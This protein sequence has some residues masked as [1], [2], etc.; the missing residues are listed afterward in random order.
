MDEKKKVS[1]SIHISNQELWCKRVESSLQAGAGWENDQHHPGLPQLP[2]ETRHQR[3]QWRPHMVLCGGTYVSSMPSSTLD[4]CANRLL[5]QKRPPLI[6]AVSGFADW[7]DLSCRIIV[8]CGSSLERHG[9]IALA[10]LFPDSVFHWTLT[11]DMS[12]T[13]PGML[14]L[15]TEASRSNRITG[16]MLHVSGD[17]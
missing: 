17:V 16:S 5:P 7:H 1:S 15:L 14:G 8:S 10:S 3:Q 4:L 6:L 2:V 9:S 13:A 11:P 12:L